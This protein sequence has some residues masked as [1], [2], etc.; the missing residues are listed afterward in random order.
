MAR[1]NNEI[2]ASSTADIAFLLLIFYL[3]TT[4]MNVDSG[5]SRVLPPLADNAQQDK[6]IDNLERNT[7]L[8]RINHQDKISVG[9]RQVDVI[10]IKDIAKEFILNPN[11]DP[12]LPQKEEQDIPLI[13]K[14]MVSKGI[15]S[16]QNDKSTSY[17]T[18]IQVQNELTKAYNEVRNEL[19]IKSFGKSATELTD[20]DQKKALTK[21]VQTKI[22]EAEARDLS[23]KK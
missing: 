13:G 10:Q 19:S 5:I 15:I 3:V 16:L 22:S 20:A 18:Y 4:T 23:K 7:L 1:P 11:D 6:G 17:D 12:N 14:Y 8:V 2:N 9:G 21:A